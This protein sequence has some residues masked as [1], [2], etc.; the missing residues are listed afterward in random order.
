MSDTIRCNVLL[1]PL[2][3]WGNPTQRP[4]DADCRQRQRAFVVSAVVNR[5][6]F[7]AH[8]ERT[9]GLAHPRR[10]AVLRHGHAHHPGPG[11]PGHPAPAEGM[12][13]LS[14]GEFWGSRFRPIIGSVFAHADWHQR[15][16]GSPVRIGL[17]KTPI[18]LDLKIMSRPIYQQQ[19][20]A[21][22]YSAQLR[23]SQMPS[24]QVLAEAFRKARY[25]F[26]QQAPYYDEHRLYIV[27]FVLS[28]SDGPLVIEIDGPYHKQRMGYD[29]TR[30]QWLETKRHCRVIRFTSKEVI[31]ELP[32]VLGIVRAWFPHKRAH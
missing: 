7:R 30:T 12:A 11:K 19:Q 22:R 5:S 27:D 4:N 18:C 15:N 21:G 17:P 25:L 26:R 2:F 31:F 3:S 28:T 24:E 1:S 13:N 8:K 14:R 16:S 29:A 6:S 10:A 9:E 20:R 32:R 23:R